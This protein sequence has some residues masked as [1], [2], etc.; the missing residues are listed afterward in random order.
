MINKIIEKI[1]SS[2]SFLITSHMSV[3]GDALG[4]ELAVY[5]L[6]TKL[7]KRVVVYNHDCVPEIYKFLPFVA[8]VKNHIR[9][10]AF[11]AGIVLDCS[12]SSRAGKVKDALS[13]VKCIINID[14]HIS[15]TMFGDINW[16]DAGI[17]ST[18]Q[19]LYALCEKLRIMDKHIALNLYTGIFTDTGNFTYASTNGETHRVVSNLMKY[20]I[21]PDTIDERLHSLCKPHDLKFIS[22]IIASLKFDAHKKICWA[23]IRHWE[24]K[25]YDLT[26]VVFSIMRLLND[27]EVFILFKACEHD[28]TRVNFR[29]RHVVDVNKVAKFF[30]GGGHKRASGTTIEDTLEGAE[31]KVISFVKRYANGIKSMR[32][33]N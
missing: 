16:V 14:H 8:R 3:E 23:R 32:G 31:R 20:N 7:Q 29:S 13:K 21:H 18:C 15:N 5:R 4:S 19:M 28:K 11:D 24:E 10:E 25:E 27:V 2:K 6:L 12:D 33:E 30:G 22:E 9:E 1:K 26:E 17:G